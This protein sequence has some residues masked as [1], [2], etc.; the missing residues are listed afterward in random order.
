VRTLAEHAGVQLED[1]A[2]AVDADIV[3]RAR[4]GD[5]MGAAKRYSERTGAGF[6]EAQRIVADL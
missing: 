1:P 2:A 4:S 3:E 6:V 5:R